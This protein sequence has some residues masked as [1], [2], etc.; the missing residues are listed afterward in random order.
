[1]S[2]S[3]QLSLLKDSKPTPICIEPIVRFALIAL[4][5]GT[6]ATGF[7]PIFV[8]LTEVGP[9]A[10][11]FWRLTLALPVFWLWSLFETRHSPALAQAGLVK[12]YSWLLLAGLCFAADTALFNLSLDYTSVANSSLLSNSAPIFVVLIAWLFL[13][14]RFSPTFVLGL[15][16]ALIGATILVGTSFTMGLD[17]L[18]G[19]FLGILTAMFYAGYI[20]SI[21]RLRRDVGSATAMV[22]SGLITAVILLG[23]SLLFGESFWALTLA[24]WLVLIGFALVSHVSGQGLI[25]YALAHLPASFS[26]VA[27]LLQPVMA[28]LLGWLILQ[29]RVG[30][31]Q[32]C[33]G[34]IVLSGIF[35]A[36]YGSQ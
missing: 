33:G 19:D 36:R 23:V 26:S 18:F 28:T 7:S 4:L 8:R 15:A 14:E 6:L 12:N 34:L 27:L 20:L 30:F 9:V 32:A 1:M 17:H 31:W 2:E 5:T 10:T 29:E 35:L 22:W 16:V 21:K 13:G 24:G 11:G 3:T 25:T